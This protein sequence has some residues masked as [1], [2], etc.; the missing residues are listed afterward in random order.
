MFVCLGTKVIHIELVT[1]LSADS[2]I[3]ALKRL[4]ARR[5]KVKSIWS[6]NSTTFVGANRELLEL[7][8]FFKAKENRDK[9]I[10]A[11]ASEGIN[12]HFIPP[13]ASQL[14]GIWVA[15]IKSV[16]THLKHVIGNASLT[17]EEFYTLFVQLEAI[18][19]SRPLIPLSNHPNNL[20]ILTLAHFL[21][22]DA[23]FSN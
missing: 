20:S 10:D 23:L 1:S 22:G 18:L 9:L 14:S 3:S 12:W 19:N 13:R 6:D 16:K 17:Y 5:G 21:I 15:G 4:I 11:T 2:F 7:P 8:T